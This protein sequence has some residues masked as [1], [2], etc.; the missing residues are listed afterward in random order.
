ML[1]TE[2]KKSGSLQ[3]RQLNK[4]CNK[5]NWEGVKVEAEDKIQDKVN[6]EWEAIPLCG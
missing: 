1:I 3:K 4:P 5:S 2:E 6:G